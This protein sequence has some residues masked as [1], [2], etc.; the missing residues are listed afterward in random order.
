MTPKEIILKRWVIERYI[1]W[2]DESFDIL[3]L[4]LFWYLQWKN[5][6]WVCVWFTVI[7]AFSHISQVNK[8]ERQLE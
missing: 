2:L 4:I 8:L 3:L 6:F 5:V 7:G 1:G